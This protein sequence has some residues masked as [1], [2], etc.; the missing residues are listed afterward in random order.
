MKTINTS[1]PTAQEI[2]AARCATLADARAM[3]RWVMPVL[4]EW[5]RGAWYM[6][7]VDANDC[8]AL[9]AA[10]MTGDDPEFQWRDI[11]RDHKAPRDSLCALLGGHFGI[12]IL[13]HHLIAA[14]AARSLD[15]LVS[16]LTRFAADDEL[17]RPLAK[18]FASFGIKLA[19]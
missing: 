3:T 4:Q 6:W 11:E 9:Q 7:L 14:E 2:V 5:P 8:R 16:H 19:A 15:G 1:A 17:A 10:R 13:A 12:V 18:S